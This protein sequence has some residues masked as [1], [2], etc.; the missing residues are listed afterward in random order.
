MDLVTGLNGLEMAG[1]DK[2]RCD[3]TRLSCTGFFF[4]YMHGH[5]LGRRWRGGYDLRDWKEA[6][7]WLRVLGGD[8]VD[9]VV[10][11]CRCCGR[12]DLAAAVHVSQLHRTI[13]PSARQPLTKPNH[14]GSLPHPPIQILLLTLAERTKPARHR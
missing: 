4:V 14:T 1:Y 5:L 9:G 7:G 11:S 6:T 3:A 12:V 10:R 13:W 8:P 2:S